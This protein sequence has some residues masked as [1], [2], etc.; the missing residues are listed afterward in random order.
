MTDCGRCAYDFTELTS[1]PIRSGSLLAPLFSHCH[2]DHL[3]SCPSA[4]AEID[5]DAGMLPEA[6]GPG[7]TVLPFLLPS[8]GFLVAPQIWQ[9]LGMLKNAVVFFE[10][11]RAKE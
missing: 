9:S 3:A 7:R 11:V 5:E 4:A 6:L 2:V 10:R 8:S 1:P